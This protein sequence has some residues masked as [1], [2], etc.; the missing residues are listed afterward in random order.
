[1][2]KPDIQTTFDLLS[3]LSVYHAPVYQRLYAWEGKQLESL[4]DDIESA[5]DKQPTFLGALVLQEMG[6]IGGQGS[7]TKYLIVDGQQRLTT[8]FLLLCAIE[9][10]AFENSISIDLDRSIVQLLESKS[11]S[12]P[13]HPKL[14]PTLQDRGVLLSILHELN[15]S[16]NWSLDTSGALTGQ[17]N[18]MA[19]QWRRVKDEVRKRVGIDAG[20]TST[21][22]GDLAKRIL[23]SLNFVVITLDD[24]DDA[25]EVFSKLNG[26]GVP[27][28]LGDLIRNEIFGKFTSGRE[29]EDFHAK[30]WSE[31][32]KKFKQADLANFF[33]VY[34]YLE[35]DGDTTKSTA[36][37][38]LQKSWQPLK[39]ADV[40]VRLKSTAEYF[41]ALNGMPVSLKL[42]A[43]VAELT[44][45]FSRMPRSFVTW[46]YLI[47]L[48]RSS[49]QTNSN[50]DNILRCLGII[51]SFLV[52][53]ALCGIEPTG[54][55]T[56]FKGL[57][58]IDP[59]ELVQKIITRTVQFPD[60]ETLTRSLTQNPS[61]SRKILPYVLQEQERDFR[62]QRKADPIT[63]QAVTIE[64]IMPKERGK[65]WQSLANA[66]DYDRLVGL[67][68]NLVPLSEPQ[69]KSTKNKPW[70]EKRVRFKGSNFQIT[71]DLA[72]ND[73]WSPEQIHARSRLIAGW[74]C[75]RWPYPNVSSSGG[76]FF[77]DLLTP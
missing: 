26:E 17:S 58:T 33:T 13:G 46:P 12:T 24:T 41:H 3:D 22:L 49:V 75:T 70:L 65:S 69:N 5:S 57:D 77:V 15:T 36:F 66:Q 21:S 68:G 51:E 74:A 63:S 44:K 14:I 61:D 50:I 2:K 52:R 16:T 4:L 40:L 45:R 56:H 55:H 31:F 8:L 11:K 37:S 35:F 9:V 34:S 73:S 30:A 10:V 39:P 23:H 47:R 1:M 67:I 59:E 18:R 42:D 76:Q 38:L 19:A 72:E 32:E 60:D 48:M 7:P 28:G 43:R 29:A 27:L 62:R 20:T 25:N 53:R 54:L 71:Q 6:R 64:H